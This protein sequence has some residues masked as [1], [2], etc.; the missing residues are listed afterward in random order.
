VKGG[1]VRV[2]HNGIPRPVP[3]G[4]VTEEV[5]R[6][7]LRTVSTELAAL[8]QPLSGQVAINGEVARSL[9]FVTGYGVEIAMLIDIW[10]R[11]DLR[12][13][14]EADMGEVQNRFKPDSALDTVADEVRQAIAMRGIGHIPSGISRLKIR[15]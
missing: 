15:Q 11:F 10:A 3:G 13:I 1:F 2:D 4:R 12:G 14:V 9:G 6:P 7:F 5:A 8:S